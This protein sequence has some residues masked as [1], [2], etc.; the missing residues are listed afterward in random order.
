MVQTASKDVTQLLIDWREGDPEALATLMPLVYEELRHQ[1]ER[2]MRRERRDHTLQ[3]TAL[4]H[5][6]Y[7][8]LV[9]QNRVQWQNRAQFFGVASELMRRIM[10]KH[11]RSHNT[12]KR[13]GQAR[14]VPLDDGLARVE[15]S[16]AELIALDEALERLAAFDPR[17][18]KI[19]E[20]R[21]FGGLTIDEAAVFLD[22]S[23]ATVKR[24]A[25]LAQ[26]WLKRELTAAAPAGG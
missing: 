18:S 26:A 20:L 12:V 2:Y 9:D 25:R 3:P 19:L 6:T 16:A 1:A 17:Q 5:E 4:V 11:A 14:R 24:E 8:Q 22:L 7:L 23:P 10:L 13:G 15:Q 21:H